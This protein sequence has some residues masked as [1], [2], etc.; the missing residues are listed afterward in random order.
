L[1]LLK[2]VILIRVLK[3]RNPSGSLDLLHLLCHRTPLITP[4]RDNGKTS[5]ADL[6]QI[7]QSVNLGISILNIIIMPDFASAIQYFIRCLSTGIE[8]Q[9]TELNFARYARNWNNG[10][11]GIFG[12]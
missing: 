2:G 10:L 7:Q 12:R 9:A 6:P 1:F 4:W 11:I 8:S 3:I 5:S